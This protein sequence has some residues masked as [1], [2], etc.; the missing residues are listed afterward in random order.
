MGG[1]ITETKDRN[2]YKEGGGVEV[3]VRGSLTAGGWGG[4]LIEARSTEIGSRDQQETATWSRVYPS[5]MEVV[6]PLRQPHRSPVDDI[7]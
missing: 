2:R 5:L 3:K 4:M 6:A 7:K 1:L